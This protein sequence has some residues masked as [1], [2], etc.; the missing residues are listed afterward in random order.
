MFSIVI[1]YYKK[2]KYIERCID[3]V[4][5]Q[6]FSD[7][8]IILI[9]DGSQDDIEELINGKYAGKV[10]LIT[11]NNQGVSVARN[12]GI[13]NAKY[14]YIAFLDADDYWS[15]FYLEKNKNVLY[16]EKDVAIVGAKY[17][18]DVD[19][20]EK[21]DVALKYTQLKKYFKKA[22]CETIFFTS[23]TIVR[24]SFFHDNE[25]FNTELSLGE[26]L[27]VW[28][29]VIAV[30]GNVFFIKNTLVY[31]SNDDLL[32]ITK[33]SVPFTKSLNSKLQ[34]IY[35]PL[36][37]K[38]NNVAFE[39][40]VAKQIYSTLSI[41]YFT[42]DT[43][44]VSKKMI[45]TNKKKYFFAELYFAIPYSIGSRYSAKTFWRK[46]TRKYFKFIFTYIYI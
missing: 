26:D 25:G 46:Y 13:A 33:S 27:D 17:S 41:R 12:T 9:D 30:G 4:L 36:F 23:A 31:Y 42:E 6:T 7:Y 10:T 32:S 1:P 43:H 24:K 14:D 37:S 44:D 35:Y 5:E 39:E 2:R 11:Q 21:Y 18:I 38:F 15:P 20:V 3:S 16:R 19:L 34:E 29:R 8:E 40:F 45:R 28:F 22:I